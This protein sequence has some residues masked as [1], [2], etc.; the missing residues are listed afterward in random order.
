MDVLNGR[1]DH[2]LFYN[3][4]N[5]YT[6]ASFSFSLKDQKINDKIKLIGDNI[7]VVGVFDRQP[8]EEESYTLEGQFVNDLKFGFQFRFK[9]FIRN[10]TNSKNGVISYLCSDLFKGVGLKTAQMI[11]DKLGVDALNIIKND[12]HA[13]DDINISPNQKMLIKS[14][15]TSDLN[16]QEIMVFLLSCGLSMDLCHKIIK[17]YNGVDI[18]A[19]IKDNPYQLMERIE[20]FGFK[21]ADAL[22]NNLGIP[23]TA[24]CRL[25]ALLTY[26]LNELLYASGNSYISKHDL[27]IALARYTK[28]E[29]EQS[30]YLEILNM[31]ENEHKIFINQYDQVF[32]YHNYI[33][34]ID[35][36]KEIVMFLKDERSEKGI[37][38]Y[39]QDLIDK[40]FEEIEKSSNISFSIEQKEAIKTAF[41][42]P[43]VI[44]T[45]GPGTGK[46]TIVHAVIKM[47]LKLNGDNSSLATSI[48]LLAP[49]G[50]AA[51]RL[52]ESTNMEAS[53]IHRFL[54]YTGDNHFA[55]NKYN[56]TSSRL[57][58]VDEA[59]MMDLPLA[60]RLVTSM[61]PDARLIIV[62][63]VDQLPSV[64]PGQV[65]KDL[66][67]TKEIQTIRLTKIHRQA[68]NSSIIKLAHSVNEGY[69]PENLMEK[70]NDRIFINTSNEALP[71]LLVDLYMKTLAK[72]K[73]IKDIQVLIPMYKGNSGINEI[74]NL[75]QERVNPLV[76]D[77]EIK[78]LGRHLRI[79]DKV[80]QL[81]NR[82]EKGVMNGDIGY[83]SGFSYKGELIKGLTVSYDLKNVNYTLEELEDI[84]LAYAI[85]IHKSQGSEFDIVI[86]PFSSQY[87]VMLE[88]KL[89]Y[90]AIT[91][92][93]KVLMMI[94]DPSMMQLG[95]KRIGIQRNTILKEK[96]I[97]FLK[98]NSITEVL[99]KYE[100]K[101]D[102]EQ[103]DEFDDDFIG[104][105]EI[106]INE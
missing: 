22:A 4:E 35:L 73:K 21:K 26:G 11:V 67:D 81:V 34:E 61:H 91:R 85:S 39:Q 18:I 82:P 1:I 59:S 6:V 55:Y 70:L 5:G 95:I 58:I 25:K 93:K 84:T 83:I 79:N 78:N 46:T 17:E 52:S 8:V 30:K 42:S 33:M 20:R 104:E 15:I 66:I 88:R 94:G 87:Y 75:I 65:L 74:N 32:D 106:E 53:T 45:G 31:L 102:E 29:I 49:T 9:K 77:K 62:G 60:S 97:E 27:Y 68:E 101:E 71:N 19:L 100:L 47:Y 24:T 90:T 14:G 23:K 63:D 92:A 41:T 7:N 43:I 98:S 96:I 89:I 50:R 72:G 69:L 99:K 3:E 105:K 13:L 80:I 76:D 37:K 54:G 51:K 40:S 57:I 12:E 38:K 56:K 48:A 64:G 36:A 86:M 10:K 103:L 28:E 16:N 2:V 44:I